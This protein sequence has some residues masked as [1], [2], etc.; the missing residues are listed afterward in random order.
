MEE[1]RVE[2]LKEGAVGGYKQEMSLNTLYINGFYHYIELASKPL[3][4]YILRGI[5]FLFP[6]KRRFI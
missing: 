1:R 3:G 4:F 2:G 5:V 6:E